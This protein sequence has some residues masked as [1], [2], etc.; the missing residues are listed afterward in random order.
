MYVDRN[1]NEEG[2]GGYQAYN[3]DTSAW[4]AYLLLAQIQG[5][6]SPYP[7]KVLPP[8]LQ[9]H[10]SDLSITAASSNLPERGE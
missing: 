7:T 3:W 6:D 1:T 8:H 4:G 9:N 10:V 5:S 2:G